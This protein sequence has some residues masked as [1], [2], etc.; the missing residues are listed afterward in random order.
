MF[1]Y[2]QRTGRFLDEGVEVAKGYSGWGAGANNPDLENLRGVGPI[3]R[4]RYMIGPP[5]FS[6]NVG[7]VAMYLWPVGHTA[8]GRSALMIHGDN[9]T[10][11][12]S[13]GC[14]IIPR[15][16]REAVAKTVMNSDDPVYLDVV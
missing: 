10:S 4:G 16:V 5:R 11:T 6:R 7:P 15:V 12:A 8:H 2:E 9:R 13:R 3:P 14:V 1:T